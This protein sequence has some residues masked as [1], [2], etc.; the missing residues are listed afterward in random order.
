MPLT[1]S[2]SAS[3]LRQNGILIEDRF[4]DMWDFLR[5]RTNFEVDQLK[6]ETVVAGGLPFSDWAVKGK[7]GGRIRPPFR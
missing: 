2:M 5:V 1:I 4:R 3:C 7:K 6:P